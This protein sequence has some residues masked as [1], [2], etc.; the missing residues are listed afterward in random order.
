MVL[1]SRPF[2]G[3]RFVWPSAAHSI[4]CRVS[5]SVF[6][7]LGA[8][9]FHVS[10]TWA[11][12]ARASWRCVPDGL[13]PTSGHF[14]HDRDGPPPAVDWMLDSASGLLLCK[15]RVSQLLSQDC[16]G[17][18][19]CLG[20]NKNSQ[21]RTDRITPRSYYQDNRT[22]DAIIQAVYRITQYKRSKLTDSA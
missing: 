3:S 20:L 1:T 10:G 13:H 21:L 14:C 11:P 18:Y 12:K 8:R 22:I 9:G 6:V 19:N 17:W 15:P 7:S 16:F 2:P 5:K 4:E